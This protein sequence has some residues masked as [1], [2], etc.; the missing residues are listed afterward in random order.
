MLNFPSD[1]LSEM[2]ELLGADFDT[3]VEVLNTKASYGLR[4]NSLKKV[5]FDTLKK[6]LNLKKD[7]PWA[8]DA[9][10]ADKDRTPGKS[11]WHEGGAIYIQDPGACL[12]ASLLSPKPGDICLDLCSAPGGKATQMA[13][14]MKDSGMLL[15]NEIVPKR[16]TVLSQNIE[17]MGLSNVLVSSCAPDELS[18]RFV[19]Y[20]DKIM[21][22]APCSGEGMFRKNPEALN[23]WSRENVHMCAE[24]QKEILDHAFMMLRKG[25]VLCYSTCTFSREEDEAIAEWVLSKYDDIDVIPVKETDFYKNLSY[26]FC[27][28][29][30]SYGISEDEKVKNSCIR[31]WPHK[32]DAEG[33]F[34]V[35]FKK[36]GEEKSNINHKKN[37]KENTSNELKNTELFL[38]ELLKS[39]SKKLKELLKDLDDRLLIFG[40]NYYLLPSDIPSDFRYKIDGLKLLRPGLLICECENKKNNKKSKKNNNH[41]D[42]NSMKPDHALSRYLDE[43]DIN[44]VRLDSS[45]ASDY[46]GGQSVILKENPSFNKGYCVCTY[47]GLSLGFAKLSNNALKNHY[48]KGLRKLNYHYE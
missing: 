33:Q 34:A 19:E 24:R 11:I 36:R 6:D 16:A 12:P 20:F 1:F 48:P 28:T 44:Y 38:R 41:I 5:D 46:I 31:V 25:G 10:Y 2:K 27:E 13:I 26:D 7:I 30:L 21:V 47:H 18:E 23:E 45:D 42:F 22:D 32:V 35:L 43:S 9:Y 29:G 40:N 17:R 8:S 15:S 14:L 3:F 37:R 39:D 4:I